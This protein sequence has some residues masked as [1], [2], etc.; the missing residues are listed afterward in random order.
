MFTEWHELS[1]LCCLK[2]YHWFN[3]AAFYVI[4]AI[5]ILVNA[6]ILGLVLQLLLLHLYLIRHKITTFDYIT[7]RVQEEVR[8]Q[9]FGLSSTRQ[10]LLAVCIDA[11]VL[12][13]ALAARILGRRLGKLL[14]SYVTV[15]CTQLLAGTVFSICPHISPPL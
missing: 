14:A 1:C 9:F 12:V 11:C 3:S 5:P 2:A 13:S 15:P 6:P 10:S 4:S 7:M 8:C